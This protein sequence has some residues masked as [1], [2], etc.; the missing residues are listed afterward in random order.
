VIL[1]IGFK[2]GSLIPESSEL[3]YT[4]AEF[5]QA[6]KLGR[7]VFPF[8]KTEG[9]VWA[10]KE[11]DAAKKKALD[12]FNNTVTSAGLTPAYFESTDEL[13]TKMLLAMTNWNAEGR[14]GARRVFTTPKEFFASF[15]SNVPR[16]FEIGCKRSAT[17]RCST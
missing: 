17:A 6:Q 4:R 14:P 2:A 12:D 13:Q 10:N 15:E 7:P 5:E 8:F 16:L 11:S 1:I 3:T 9:R